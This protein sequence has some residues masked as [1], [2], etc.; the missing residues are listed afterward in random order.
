MQNLVKIQ[1]AN[2]YSLFNSVLFLIYLRVPS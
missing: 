2:G 1:I